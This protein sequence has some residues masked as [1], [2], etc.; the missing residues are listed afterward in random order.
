LRFGLVEKSPTHTLYHRKFMFIH[1]GGP[2]PWQCTGG[3]IRIVIN[4]FSGSQS[5]MI[6]VM[7]QLTSTRLVVWKSVDDTHSIACSL[8][9]SWAYCKNACSE[10]CR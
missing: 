7:A 10:L 3:G 2:N 9:D 5:L 4:N 6:T 8:C 1:Y